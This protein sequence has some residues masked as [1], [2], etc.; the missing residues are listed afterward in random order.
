MSEETI[1]RYF[2]AFNDGDIETMLECVTPDIVH[3]V[4]E[5]HARVGAGTV[6]PTSANTCRAITGKSCATSSC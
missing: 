5:G 4:N 2:R 6:S 3:N 1:R